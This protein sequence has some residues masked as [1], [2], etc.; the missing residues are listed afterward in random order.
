MAGIGLGTRLRLGACALA[1]ITTTTALG[2]I[3]AAH[4]GAQTVSTSPQIRVLSNRADKGVK[5][6]C[7]PPPPAR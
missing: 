2:A 5:M 6:M 1:A 4:V 3:G 7:P